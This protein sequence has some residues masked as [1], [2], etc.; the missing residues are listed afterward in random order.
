MFLTNIEIAEENLA[1]AQFTIR[2]GRKRGHGSCKQCKQQ[3][4]NWKKPNLCSCGFELG[5]QSIP[6]IKTELHNNLL[7]VIV[8][9]NTLG[10]LKPVKLTS[11]DDRQFVFTNDSEKICYA[12]N[13]LG[14]RGSYK[15]WNLLAKFTCKN[16]E[17][18][19]NS[20]LYAVNFSNNDIV[21]ATPDETV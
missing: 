17:A 11:N 3:Y 15:T 10:A 2:K 9:E 8:Y 16:I 14:I 13:C 5:D 1:R 12:K 18:K 20:C 7:S 6:K 21:E 4:V 19:V